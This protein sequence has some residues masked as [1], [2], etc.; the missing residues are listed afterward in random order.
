MTEASPTPKPDEPV[1]IERANTL[2]EKTGGSLDPSLAGKA[3]QS[4]QLMAGDF[5]KWLEDVVQDMLQARTQLASSPL[6]RTATTSLYTKALEVKSLGETYGFALVTRFANS[7]CKLLIKLDGERPAPLALVDAHLDAIRAAL[8]DNMRT[9]D[10]PVGQALATEL[11]RQVT[12]F[13]QIT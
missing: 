7:L 2:R 13:H 3:D 10:H 5:H 8:R 11:E 4:V 6:T 9:A 12:A 1:I